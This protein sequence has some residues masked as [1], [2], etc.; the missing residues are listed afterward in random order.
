[1]LCRHTSLRILCVIPVLS[2]CC[3]PPRHNSTPYV[4]WHC[5][6]G[7]SSSPQTERVMLAVSFVVCTSPMSLTICCQTHLFLCL[8]SSSSTIWERGG[9]FHMP[10]WMVLLMS[11]H[12]ESLFG[13]LWVLLNSCQWKWFCLGWENIDQEL[14][15]WL[16]SKWLKISGS[17]GP[18]W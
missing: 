7:S 8:I 6:P 15:L 12:S 18:A 10:N 3:F 4:Q 9:L 11:K 16:K 14:V 5:L 2:L 17:W 13:F 1:M